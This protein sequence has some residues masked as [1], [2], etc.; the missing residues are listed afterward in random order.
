MI[1]KRLNVHEKNVSK[2]FVTDN[3]KLNQI[4]SIAENLELKEEVGELKRKSRT[5]NDR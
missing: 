3:E 2:N 5:W 1:L 4:D